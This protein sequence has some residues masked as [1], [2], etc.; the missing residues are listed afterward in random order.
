MQNGQAPDD[1][2]YVPGLD[3]RMKPGRQEPH[4]GSIR[5]HM[6]RMQELDDYNAYVQQM[7]QTGSD[8]QVIN[9]EY[10]AQGSG[11]SSLFPGEGAEG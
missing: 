6:N 3:L 7:H 9:V 5:N 1:V 10:G 8:Y 2:Q 11:P 4:Y